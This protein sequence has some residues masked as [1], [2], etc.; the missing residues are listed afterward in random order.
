MLICGGMYS[1]DLSCPVGTA[2]HAAF[3]WLGCPAI[4]RDLSGKLFSA[5]NSTIF[6]HVGNMD[7]L[8]RL[9]DFLE[10]IGID[11]AVCGGYGIDLFIGQKTRPHKDLDVTAFWEDRDTIIRFMI[12]EGWDVYEPC[13]T[14][15]LHKISN[16][17][18]QRRIKSNIWCVKQGNQH[19]RFMENE[20]SMYA[21]DFDNLEQNELDYVEFLFNSRSDDNFLFARNK[22]IKIKLETSVLKANN[23][24]FLAPELILL[25]KSNAA[26]KTE[27][28][29]DFISASSM[30]NKGQLAWLKNALHIMYPKGHVWI[31]ELMINYCLAPRG[32]RHL[33]HPN[34]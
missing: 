34:T 17:Q 23:I 33:L 5:G 14:E 26:D 8:F 3:D 10:K 9:N 12:R 30:M 32:P 27:Y 13:G 4:R 6:D 22:A 21:V 18:D 15:Y 11:Y 20:D 24:P 1:P 29:Q 25:Y 16:V 19:Y 7:L 28:Q 2:C 31:N